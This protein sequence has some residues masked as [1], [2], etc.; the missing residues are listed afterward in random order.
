MI[1]KGLAAAIIMLGFAATAQDRSPSPAWGSNEIRDARPTIQED[2]LV[3]DISSEVSQGNRKAQ[4]TTST[5]MLAQDFD[6]ITT[7]SD[8]VLDDYA[9]CRTLKWS[10]RKPELANL[11]CYALPAFLAN[12]IINRRYTSGLYAQLTGSA[13]KPAGS[14]GNLKVISDPYWAETELRV[15]EEPETRLRKRAEGGAADYLHGDKVVARVSGSVTGL[16]DAQK[17]EFAR[18]L[19]RN[20]PLHPELRADVSRYLPERLEF[21]AADGRQIEHHVL[22]VSNLRRTKAEYPLPMGMPAASLD[23]PNDLRQAEGVEASI[24]AAEGRAS[25]PKPSLQMIVATIKNADAGGQETAVFMLFMQLVQQY[26]SEITSPTMQDELAVVR[27]LVPRALQDPEVAKFA[28]AS[29]LAADAKASGDRE[30]A[31]RYLSGANLWSGVPFGTF[32]YVT[33]ANLV[34]SSDTS[35]WSPEV[36]KSMPSPLDECYWT[37]IAAYPWA[38]N[39]YK[40]LGDTY[41]AE[42]DMAGAWNAYDL[43]RAVDP[44]WRVG[45]MS[46]IAQ[47]E[48]KLRVGLADF[49]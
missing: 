23:R 43:G 48:D 45:V 13:N 15:Q 2:V 46:S 20:Q 4:R 28:R 10:D 44:N 24:R 7:G 25:T 37:H 34:R 19:A 42:Y 49:F 5:V 8:R 47:L 16:D 38:S 11:S 1:A 6:Y 18:Y 17:H 29:D 26:R 32:R 9:L 40:D 21:D 30:A 35:K 22:I 14:T 33:F 41:F 31:A 27:S 3:F 39:A 36:L 12:E